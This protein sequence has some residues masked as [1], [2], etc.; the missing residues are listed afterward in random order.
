MTQRTQNSFYVGQ[1]ECAARQFCL[2]LFVCCFCFV[3]LGFVVVVVCFVV[4]YSYH[5]GALL[6]RSYIY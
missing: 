1:C 3:V 4:L 5:A 6:R 2:F